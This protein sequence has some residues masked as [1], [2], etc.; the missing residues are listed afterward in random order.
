MSPLVSRACPTYGFEIPNLGEPK[1]GGECDAGGGG[2]NL[3]ERPRA[4]ALRSAPRAIRGLRAAGFSAGCRNRGDRAAV[5]P[6]APCRRRRRRYPLSHRRP[7]A[8]ALDA[9]FAALAFG[10]LAVALRAHRHAQSVAL[11]L[12]CIC[13]GL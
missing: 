6:L 10:A 12:C 7:G 11:V 4:G 2:N 5:F 3:C 9:G 1:L 8:V 13:L